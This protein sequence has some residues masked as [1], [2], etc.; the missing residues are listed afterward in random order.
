MTSKFLH[1]MYNKTIIRFGF[2]DIQNNQGLKIL[3]PTSTLIILDITNTSSNNCLIMCLSKILRTPQSMWHNC[4]A[5]DGMDCQVYYQ[6]LIPVFWLAVSYGMVYIIETHLLTRDFSCCCPA[7]YNK[8]L[9]PLNF[10]KFLGS[11]KLY[12]VWVQGNWG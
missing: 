3:T 6:W 11:F 4:V 9:V 1:S 10:K 7:Q 5:H 2:C 8:Q 12:E